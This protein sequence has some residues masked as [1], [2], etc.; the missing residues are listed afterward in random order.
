MS[1]L[2]L[3][4]AEAAY[5]YLVQ[6]LPTAM[7][8]YTHGE[9]N[10]FE[11]FKAAVTRLQNQHHEF[12]H[13]CG[14]PAGS[15]L[16]KW[17]HA[18]TTCTGTLTPVGASPPK[19]SRKMNKKYSSGHSGRRT[20]RR[21]WVSA[22]A[23]ECIPTS[24]TICRLRFA[25]L[26]EAPG[27]ASAPVEA[28]LQASRPH[29]VE[30]V[31]SNRG[32]QDSTAEG[33]DAAMAAFASSSRRAS[34]LSTGGGAASAATTAPATAVSAAAAVVATGP[35]T[36]ASAAAAADAMRPYASG[37]ISQWSKGAPDP[38]AA[39]S[40]PSAKDKHGAKSRA[41]SFSDGVERIIS[42]SDASSAAIVGELEKMQSRLENILERLLAP[43]K[44][45]HRHRNRS[46]SWSRGRHSGHRD[47]RSVDRRSVEHDSRSWSRGESHRHSGD[48]DRRSVDRRSV[49][50]DSRSRSRSRDSGEPQ[51]RSSGRDRRSVDPRTD[52]RNVSNS[53]GRS[54][55][56]NASLSRTASQSRTSS[57]LRRSEWGGGAAAE[58]DDDN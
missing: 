20:Q 32:P 40:H 4:L 35:R 33:A 12:K 34:P 27:H 18:P 57:E 37:P 14:S 53:G 55:M 56:H 8:R 47:R 50:H 7:L 25:V 51:H 49:D 26:V 23:C 45:P 39:T 9:G 31:P 1:P 44:D 6:V 11:A 19:L 28:V 36:V 29:F 3:L 5:L 46:R 58:M 24:Y 2:F 16:P 13:G 48:R 30:E 15:N 52:E 17:H 42:A 38:G 41:T 54:R 43:E 21:A 22:F 10:G